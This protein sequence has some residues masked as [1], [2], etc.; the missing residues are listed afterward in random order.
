MRRL[1][2]QEAR[3][4]GQFRLLPFLSAEDNLRRVKWFARGVERRMLGG[5]DPVL[6]KLR[7]K[8]RRRARAAR[9]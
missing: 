1:R 8:N 6:R 4:P 7:M 5:R 3:R 9:T 2:T